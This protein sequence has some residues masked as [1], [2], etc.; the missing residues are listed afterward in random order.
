MRSSI[1]NDLSGYAFVAP[2]LIGFFAFAL[3][4][5]LSTLYL[6]FTDFDALSPPRWVGLDNYIDLVG[7]ADY[8]WRSLYNT[9]FMLIEVPLSVILGLFLAILL[10]ANLRGQAV[11]RALFYVPAVV[12]TV[13][14]SFLWLWTLN[15]VNGLAAPVNQAL[16][17]V[18][19]EPVNWFTDPATAK[20]GFIVMD[21]WMIG[22]AMVIYLAALQNAPIALYE[23]AAL[24]GARPWQMLRYITV[25]FISPVIF[26]MSV[27]GVIGAFQYF[28]QTFVMT[29]GGP[30][31]STLFYSLYLFQNAF[32][33]FRMG[34]ACAM[35][36]M[37]FLLSA[38]CVWLIWRSS[39][40][41]VY[42]AGE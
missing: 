20:W 15:P 35:A 28:A 24:D 16:G 26:Y 40:R 12:P 4:P 10:N 38:L 30:E 32:S 27:M 18:G 11:F 21:L 19:L 39:R 14:A 1:K 17:S 7:D 5:V 22:G 8:F 25:P 36:W 31:N 6:S 2:W 29:Q 9:A 37:L 41:W 23:A 13:A 34:H 33:Y 3:Y 42:Y